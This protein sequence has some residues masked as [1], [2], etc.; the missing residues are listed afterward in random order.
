MVSMRIIDGDGHV[1]EDIPEIIRHLPEPYAGMARRSAGGGVL[2]FVY[3]HPIVTTPPDRRRSNHR[4]VFDPIDSVPHC[5]LQPA[6]NERP[7]DPGT[8]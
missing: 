4:R 3:P 2:S 8:A 1:N 6:L 7:G 5:T